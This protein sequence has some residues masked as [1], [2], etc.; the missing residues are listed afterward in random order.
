[1][2]K[3]KDTVFGKI[4]RGEIPAKFHYRDSEVASFDSL[5]PQPP[6]HFLVIPIKPIPTMTDA[7]DEDAAVLGHMLVV[8]AKVAAEKGLKPDGYK[9]FINNRLHGGQTV[10]HVHAH[11]LDDS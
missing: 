3:P 9:V 8:A 6:I 10:F 2:A 1:M 11:V 7:T 5:R 4:L